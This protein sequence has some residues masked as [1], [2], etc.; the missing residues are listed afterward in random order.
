MTS[1]RQMYAKA[2]SVASLPFLLLAAVLVISG[3]SS[4]AEEKASLTFEEFESSCIDLGHYD[5]EARKLTVRFV[6]RKSERFYRYSNVP[7]EVWAKL[8]SLNETGGVGN[9]L[10][11]TILGNSKRYPYEEVT[12]HNF[13]TAPRNKKA[14]NSK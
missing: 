11:E 12:F 3:V 10:H 1:A 8:Q 4:A 6:N 7:R 2:G 14:G 9:Y 5:A 13:K